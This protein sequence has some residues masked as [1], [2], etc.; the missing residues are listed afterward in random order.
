VCNLVVTAT[1]TVKMPGKIALLL[2]LILLLCVANT[3]SYFKIQEKN[4]H[5]EKARRILVDD[6]AIDE[7]L[8]YSSYR[9]RTF[10]EHEQRYVLP[11]AV[12]EL[13][14]V[15]F[16]FMNAVEELNNLSTDYHLLSASDYFSKSVTVSSQL[17]ERLWSSRKML[18]Q[19]FTKYLDT[20]HRVLKDFMTKTLDRSKTEYDRMVNA[21]RNAP[22][23]SR[24]VFNYSFSFVDTVTVIPISA[25]KKNGVVVWSEQFEMIPQY[26]KK[27]DYFIQSPG[28]ATLKE[29]LRNLDG[30]FGEKG[31]IRVYGKTYDLNNLTPAALHTISKY[32]K[33]R[34][35]EI[36]NAFRRRP[37][38]YE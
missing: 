18:D 33:A 35:I 29:G 26:L 21:M 2:I 6:G 1:M 16:D 7:Y 11:T 22:K 32:L 20:D 28:I 13:S 38:L 9:N 17:Q 14:Q 19:T 23:N 10:F 3:V 5:L 37:N 31:Q 12:P 25:V 36:N 4:N 15:V 30:S 27:L 24:N 34:E 8:S